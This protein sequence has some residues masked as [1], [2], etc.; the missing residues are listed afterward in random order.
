MTRTS[1]LFK[2]LVILL[3]FPPLHEGVRWNGECELL[4]IP[5]ANFHYFFLLIKSTFR[6]LLRPADF[7]P[8]FITT[9]IKRWRRDKAV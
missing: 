8:F 1:K 9:A 7:H 4:N 6:Q 3:V 5:A 2:T